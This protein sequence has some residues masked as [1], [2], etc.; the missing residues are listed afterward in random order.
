MST[1]TPTSELEAVNTMLSCIGEA[2]I[3]DIET[4]GSVRV[5]QAKAMLNEIS[6]T[7]QQRGWHFNSEDDYPLVRNG[8][9]ELV[10]PTN[11]FRVCA[12]R[13]HRA[14]YDVVQRGTKL[15]D[16]KN[17]TFTFTVDLK[18]DIV[19]CLPFEELPEA[20][21][22]YINIFAARTFQG[23]VQGSEA[24]YRFTSEDLGMA[25]RDFWDADVS[26]SKAN[27]FTG[28]ASMLEMIDRRI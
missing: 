3:S 12:A 4:T 10:L 26:T 1:T 16:R 11:T 23:R 25:A 28:S 7:V 13:E 17:H 5:D 15:Y 19:L 9:G 2:P 27:M 6:R 18:V 22:K 21:R 14:D 20:A 8:T 24:V